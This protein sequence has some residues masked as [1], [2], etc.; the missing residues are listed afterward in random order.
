MIWPRFNPVAYQTFWQY[1]QTTNWPGV[2]H[3]SS[4]RIQKETHN[5]GIRY[6]EIRNS[7]RIRDSITDLFFPFFKIEEM[8]L[9]YGVSQRVTR[10][11]RDL[12][13]FLSVVKKGHLRLCS[14]GQCLTDWVT[15]KTWR[16]LWKY[17]NSLLFVVVQIVSWFA[18]LKISKKLTKKF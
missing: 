12:F 18:D 8:T 13:C 7:I 2:T 17:T 3:V 5:S 10:D 6:E 14:R 1:N 9:S 16:E 11:P 15:Q 4:Y